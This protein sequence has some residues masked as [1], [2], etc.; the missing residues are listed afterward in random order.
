MIAR[1]KEAVTAHINKEVGPNIATAS[2][3]V[4]ENTRGEGNAKDIDSQ[5]ARA[6]EVLRQTNGKTSWRGSTTSS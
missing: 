1:A 3:V 6:R 4:L 2:T 5:L